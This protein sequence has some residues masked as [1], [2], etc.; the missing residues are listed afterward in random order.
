MSS[1]SVSREFAQAVFDYLAALGHPAERVLQ[2]AEIDGARLVATSRVPL[3]LYERLF[4]AGEALTGDECFGVNMGAQPYPRSWGLVSH[5]AVSAP[6]AMAAA[7][8]LMD[9]SELQLNFLHFVLRDIDRE[10]RCLEIQHE[11]RRPLD[12]HVV[13]HLLV[14]VTVLAGTQIGYAVPVTEIELA[15]G[16]TTSAKR[17]SE[18]LHARVTL[19]ADA[20]RVR[21]AP[22]FLQQEALYGEEELYRVTRDL[23]QER[24][25]QLR[26]EDRF[27]NA[28]RE[29]VLDL[30]P[31]GLPK[32]A[33]VAEQLDMSSRT[34]QRRLGERNL[35]FQKVLDE[36]RGELALNLIRDGALSLDEVADQ[37]GFNDQ[38][39]FQHAF[40]RWQ[41]VTPGSYRRKMQA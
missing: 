16:N 21:T 35:R 12:R 39:A 36:V 6:D 40:R 17:L 24:L 25:S 2:A 33:A 3:A 14:N 32:V 28:V 26:R 27:L 20:Y 7:T 30:L 4:Q 1:P 5:L 15:H 31:G 34:L 19:D 22:E 18:L 38:S 9:Y 11:G 13:E 10:S 29:T 23:A 8:A 41:G 37:L